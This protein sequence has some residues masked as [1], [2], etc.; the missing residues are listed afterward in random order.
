M[1]GR[2]T[3]AGRQYAPTATTDI[4]LMRVRLMATTD[5]TGLSAEY[6]SAP[7]HGMG[8][9]TAVAA[10]GLV[11]ITVVAITAAVA[12]GVVVAGA[13]VAQVMVAITDAEAMATLAAPTDAQPT[14]DAV[15]P[16]AATVPAPEG[17]TAGAVVS[18]G[19]AAV[20]DAD[21]EAINPRDRNEDATGASIFRTADAS[22]GGRFR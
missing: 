2:D 8:D 18:T 17:S 12:I 7:G 11:A 4:H 3:T 22:V 19:A 14:V 10:G 6:S 9:T 5:L 16:G 21:E 15:M 1:S 13:M 20:A